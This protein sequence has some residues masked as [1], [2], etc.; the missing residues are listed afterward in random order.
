M[1]DAYNPLFIGGF[2]CDRGWIFLKDTGFS[3]QIKFSAD[4]HVAIYVYLK[5]GEV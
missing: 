3:F 1:P 4:M 5:T 2:I